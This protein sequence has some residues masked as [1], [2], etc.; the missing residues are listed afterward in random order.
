MYGPD[1]DALFAAVEPILRESPLAV[2]GHAIKR[3][4][5]A[6]DPDAKN[7]RIDF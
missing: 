7:V 4:G 3:Y 5:K 2:G 6:V 1:A